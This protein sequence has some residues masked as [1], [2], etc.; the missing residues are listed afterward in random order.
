[1]P[2]NAYRKL[3]GQNA[4]KAWMAYEIYGLPTTILLLDRA[5]KSTRILLDKP[6]VP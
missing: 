2:E 4:L 1:M 5:I 3:T 6:V